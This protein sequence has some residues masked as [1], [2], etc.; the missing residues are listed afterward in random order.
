MDYTALFFA[1]TSLVIVVFAIVL[2]LLKTIRDDIKSGEIPNKIADRIINK[3]SVKIQE[4]NPDSKIIKKEIKFKPKD[5]HPPYTK[6]KTELYGS[7]PHC[8]KLVSNDDICCS[9]CG[10]QLD[11]EEDV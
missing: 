9:R 5:I 10:T 4:E 6:D 11:W 8:G 3:M 1:Y 7:C 2:A